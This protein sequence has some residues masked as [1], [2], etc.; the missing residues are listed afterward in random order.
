MQ[1][2]SNEVSYKQALESSGFVELPSTDDAH[3]SY[4]TPPVG[5]HGL[6]ERIINAGPV[7]DDNPP[8]T[9]R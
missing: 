5:V 3:D 9:P 4:V 6:L 2:N 1:P 8:G 7:T